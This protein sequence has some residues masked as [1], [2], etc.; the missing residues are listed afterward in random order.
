M[1]VDEPLIL[2]PVKVGTVLRTY[3]EKELKVNGKV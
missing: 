3:K 1:S 2:F